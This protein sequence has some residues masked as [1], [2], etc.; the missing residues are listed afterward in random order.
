MNQQEDDG[1]GPD[2]CRPGKTDTR[3]KAGKD[4]CESTSLRFERNIPGVGFAEP[5][6][7]MFLFI[8]CLIEPR[9]RK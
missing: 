2:A 1:I 5:A 7:S 4:E 6:P 3:K 8:R 9:E